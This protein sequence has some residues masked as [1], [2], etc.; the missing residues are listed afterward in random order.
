LTKFTFL[1]LILV[2]VVLVGGFLF[3]HR[4]AM[5]RLVAKPV[6]SEWIL[7]A[8]VVAGLGL[9]LNLYGRNVLLT[10]QI[11]PRCDRVLAVEICKNHAG[12]FKRDQV[13]LTENKDAQRFAFLDFSKRYFK[14]AQ[15]S[16]IGIMAHRGFRD[17]NRGEL[18]P[19]RHLYNIFAVSFLL[20][21]GVLIRNKFFWIYLGTSVFYVLVVMLDN[22]AGY[23][24]YGVFG[25]GLQGRY[26]FPVLAPLCALVAYVVFFRLKWHLSLLVLGYFGWNFVKG[27]YFYFLRHVDPS[28]LNPLTG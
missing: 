11:M 24:K 9:N 25:A 20:S 5:Q 13:H 14:A 4:D 12:E 3:R 6:F 27:G 16:M 28:W 18:R 23:L 17:H 1:P 19:Y 15:A 22:Y 26:W 21:L 10:G 7:F 2:F 8:F